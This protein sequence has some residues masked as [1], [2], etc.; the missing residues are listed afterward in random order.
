MAN[1]RVANIVDVRPDNAVKEQK[2]I[3]IKV[4]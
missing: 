3:R 4:E 2:V 1:S